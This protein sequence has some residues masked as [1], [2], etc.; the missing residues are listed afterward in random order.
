MLNIITRKYVFATKL[1]MIFV[2]IAKLNVCAEPIV[3]RLRWY[4][5]G[6][7]MITSPEGV[8]VLIDPFKNLDYPEPKVSPDIILVSHEHF[9]SNN[10]NVSSNTARIIRGL[11]QNT[12]NDVNVVLKDVKITNV[13]SY[14]DKSHGA[15]RG[16]NSIFIIKTPEL[17]YVH[18]G[19]LGHILNEKQIEKIGKADVLMIPVGGF[20]VLD[21]KDATRVMKKLAPRITIPMY[22]ATPG[23]TMMNLDL[24]ENF[25]KD[26]KVIKASRG[27]LYFDYMK[28]PSF[29]TVILMDWQN[30]KAPSGYNRDLSLD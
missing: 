24:V 5:Q 28:L 2:F 11:R 9:D 14:H 30:P 16:L 6:C 4:G 20:Y 1:C 19:N 21:Y 29:G 27:T 18:L 12:L 13:L 26:K 7:F 8:K 17:S 22:Y 3:G 10:V 25:L 15:L 23:N